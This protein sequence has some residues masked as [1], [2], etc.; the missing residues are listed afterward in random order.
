MTL[1]EN[2]IHND[3]QLDKNWR[4]NKCLRCDKKFKV[5][6]CERNDARFVRFCKRCK[7]RVSRGLDDVDF[8]ETVGR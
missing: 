2:S 4:I 5:R 8:T 3:D 6:N 7:G 1:E